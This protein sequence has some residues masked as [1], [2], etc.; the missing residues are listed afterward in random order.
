MRMVDSACPANSF[1]PLNRGLDLWLLCLPGQSGKNL[2]RDV[3]QGWKKPNNGTVNGT[4]ITR[5]NS[6]ARAGG[7]GA[8]R[9]DASSSANHILLTSTTTTNTYSVSF[10]FRPDSANCS[11][12]NYAAV[13]ANTGGDTAIFFKPND[14][15]MAIYD[16]GN[17]MNSTAVTDF[18]WH[19]FV[20]VLGGGNVQWYLN[21]KDD[22]LVAT[23]G[24]PTQTYVKIG[25]DNSTVERLGGW[26]DDM[27]V[28]GNRRLTA[29]DVRELYRESAAGYPN[30]LRWTNQA[31]YFTMLEAASDGV[32]SRYLTLLGVG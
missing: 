23:S 4:V 7:W 12:G 22:G 17:R 21:G 26:L 19:H 1:H 13:L 2:W 24:S 27:R 20:A 25:N 16:G 31:S 28:W 32:S 9:F 18:K 11:A 15:K 14:M 6:F 3:R 30:A 8:Y 29:S 10:W 5:T